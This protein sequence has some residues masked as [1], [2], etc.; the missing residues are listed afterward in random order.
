MKYMS[1]HSEEKTEENDNLDENPILITLELKESA[2]GKGVFAVVDFEVGDIVM[3]DPI[4]RELTENS[5]H[6][7]QIEANRFVQHGGLIPNVNHS[8]SPN[9]G[10]IINPETGAHGFVAVR[11]IKPGDELT[12]DYSTRNLEISYFDSECL[13]DSDN[14]RATLKGWKDL[15]QE[16]KDAILASNVLVAPYLLER[17]RVHT[18]LVKV[19]AEFPMKQTSEE[20]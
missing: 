8:C 18:E 9:C 17:D 19:L 20:E 11:P 10:I 16:E 6:A 15:S 14:C 7:A 2:K 12:F 4:V 1:D 3:N 5:Q 13:C